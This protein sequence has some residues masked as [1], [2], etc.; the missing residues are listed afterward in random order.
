MI[1]RIFKISKDAATNVSAR[2]L[3]NLFSADQRQ[4]RQVSITI[5]EFYPDRKN[6]FTLIPVEELG[7]PENELSSLFFLG[8]SLKNTYDGFTAAAFAK[9]LAKAFAKPFKPSHKLLVKDI[10]L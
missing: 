3:A 5:D 6:P 2:N 8:H 10:Y 1:S 4:S 7:A 9:H